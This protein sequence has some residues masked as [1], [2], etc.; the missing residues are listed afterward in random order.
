VGEGVDFAADA[1]A[2][3]FRAL[4]ALDGAGVVGDSADGAEQPEE[5]RADEEGDAAADESAGGVD[6]A[7]ALADQRHDVELCLVNGEHADGF[8]AGANGRGDVQHG[9]DGAL[10]I[11]PGTARAVSAG[12]GA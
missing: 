4:A 6:D 2:G 11:E 8:G 3:L 7:A 9:A 1:D 12:E 5:D 10:R